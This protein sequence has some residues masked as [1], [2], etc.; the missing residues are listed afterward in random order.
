MIEEAPS[1]VLQDAS[2]DSKSH[3]VED[4]VEETADTRVLVRCQIKKKEIRHFA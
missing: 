3:D 1:P 2:S 4:I